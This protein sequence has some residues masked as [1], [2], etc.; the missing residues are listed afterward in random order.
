MEGSLASS[1]LEVIT[2][3]CHDAR[4]SNKH[5]AV[6]K[7]VIIKKDKSSSNINTTTSTTT[8]ATSTPTTSTNYNIKNNENIYK[9][10]TYSKSKN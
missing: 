5:N 10:K 1:Q 3:L 6:G 8:N 2:I 4:R 9:Q 7:I